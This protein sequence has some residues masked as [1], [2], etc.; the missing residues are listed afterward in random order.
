LK[1]SQNFS[2]TDLPNPHVRINFKSLFIHRIWDGRKL[3]TFYHRELPD[4][5]TAF[6]VAWEIVDREGAQFIA[7]PQPHRFSLITVISGSLNQIY[8]KGQTI[9][10]PKLASALTATEPTSVLQITTP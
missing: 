6:G 10:L 1:N 8:S 3:E 9:L 7:N 4:P 2:F 5:T